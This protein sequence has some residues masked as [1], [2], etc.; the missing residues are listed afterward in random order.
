MREE[1]MS[2]KG[3][4]L[5]GGTQIRRSDKE[6]FSKNSTLQAPSDAAPKPEMS[7]SERLEYDRFKRLS[8]TGSKLIP[9][10]E[11]KHKRRRRKRKSA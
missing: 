8:Q 2:R 6:W 4:Y 10:G 9:A 1:K 11:G 7:L 5:G 3:H